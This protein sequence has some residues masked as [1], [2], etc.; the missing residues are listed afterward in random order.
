MVALDSLDYIVIAGYFLVVF[1]IAGW[2]TFKEKVNA[3]SADY[4]LGGKNVDGS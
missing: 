4:F 2:S 3:S 1:G